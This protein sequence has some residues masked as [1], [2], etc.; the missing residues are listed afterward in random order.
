M[1]LYSQESISSGGG[2]VVVRDFYSPE[3]IQAALDYRKGF[4]QMQYQ[5]FTQR[6][7]LF[8]PDGDFKNT[9][10]DKLG[11]LMIQPQFREI[12]RPWTDHSWRCI[13]NAS[14]GSIEVGISQYRVGGPGYRW[15]IDHADGNR[16]V[17]NFIINLNSVPDG[18][19]EWCSAAMEND[20]LALNCPLE[21]M[22]QGP[23]EGYVDPVPG[24]LTILP[25]HY[26]HR[27]CPSPEIRITMHGH[28]RL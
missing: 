25:S 18:Q 10:G 16:R 21:D 12:I 20:Q 28:L 17:S 26:P 3:E 13:Y 24:Q 8:I 5:N 11:R 2:V 9:L 4:E 1:K 6:K 22:F 23:A 27:V 14:P 15:H 7:K 19:L